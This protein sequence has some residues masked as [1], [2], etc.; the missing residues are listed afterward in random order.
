MTDNL[1]RLTRRLASLNEKVEPKP[2]DEIVIFHLPY[3][4]EVVVNPADNPKLE[5]RNRGILLISYRAE[6]DEEEAEINAKARV[7]IDDYL[8]TIA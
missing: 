5:V 6:T 1:K 3:E 2:L 8:R 4:D 7:L